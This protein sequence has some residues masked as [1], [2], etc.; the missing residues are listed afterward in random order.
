VFKSVKQCDE[1]ARQNSKALF[2]FLLSI[3]KPNIKEALESSKTKPSHLS[4]PS[5]V[6]LSNQNELVLLE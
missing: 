3:K 4:K 5:A 6:V 2:V 1:T